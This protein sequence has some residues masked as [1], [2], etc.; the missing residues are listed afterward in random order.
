MKTKY[1]PTP[2]LDRMLDVRDKSQIIGEFIEWLTEQSIQ[3]CKPHEH[4]DE[5][6][7]DSGHIS[8]DMIRGELWP[9]H[10][11]TEKLLAQYFEIDLAKC[12]EERR[13]ILDSLRHTRSSVLP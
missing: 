7:E 8:C 2:E 9:V 6:Y 12:E 10:I 11:A 4:S 5:C 3:L 1:P 13:A